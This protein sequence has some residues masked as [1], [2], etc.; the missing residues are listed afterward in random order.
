VAFFRAW[1]WLSTIVFC[2]GGCA[3]SP[4]ARYERA[5]IYQPTKTP[6]GA[7]NA[8]RAGFE[9]ASFTAADGTRLSGWFADHPERRAVV[10][11]AHGNG[12]NVEMWAP[13]VRELADRHRVAALVFDYR[14]YGESEGRPREA[15]VLQ[16]SRAAR[17]WLAERTGVTEDSIVMMGQS[18]G[19]GVAIDLAAKDGARALVLMSTFTSV[20]DVAAQHVRWLPTNLVMTERFRSLDKIKHYHG[21]LLICHGDADRMIPFTHGEQLFA[22][23]P[24]TVKQFVR[25]VGGDHNDPP[26][27]EYHAAL[28]QLL[29]ALPPEKPRR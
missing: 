18:L 1:A 9:Q 29:D 15:G 21:P 17:R 4:L 14:G 10:L 25:H 11:F 6:A 19:G 2:A 26:P 24:G 22:A 28:A 20:P 8:A 3:L 12:G 27:P 5:M 13:L 23:A 16:D 7:S